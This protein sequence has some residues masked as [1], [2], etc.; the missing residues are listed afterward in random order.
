[1]SAKIK[2]SKAAESLH[3]SS[4]V[5]DSLKAAPMNRN[6]SPGSSAVESML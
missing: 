6:I 4:L 2:V 1:M 3:S 5:I